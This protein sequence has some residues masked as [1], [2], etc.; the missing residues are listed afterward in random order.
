MTPV[1]ELW[2][3]VSFSRETFACAAA[4]FCASVGSLKRHRRS[5]PILAES[6]FSFGQL[7][8]GQ[9]LSG[10]RIDKG[11]EARKRVMLDV[12]EIKPKRKFVDVAPDVLL[13]NVVIDA[14]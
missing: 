1:F 12:A 4:S 9:S 10:N 6:L 14:D 3:G 7:R 8:V 11:V 2:H 5:D 13:V